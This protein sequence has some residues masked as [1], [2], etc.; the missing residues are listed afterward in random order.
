MTEIS[1]SQVSPTALDWALRHVR[2]HGDTDIFPVPFEYAVIEYYWDAVRDDLAKIPLGQAPLRA[3]VAMCI[4]KTHIGFR[5]AHQLDPFD[6][7]MYTAQVY[8]M[9]TYI[10]DSRLDCDVACSYRFKPTEDG[11]FYPSDNGWRSYVNRSRLLAGNY[12][13]VLYIDI[14]DFYNQIYHHRLCGSLEK[15]GIS[16]TRAKNVEKFLGRF[17]AR[18]SRGIPVGPS[19]SSLL[20]ECC[21]NDVDAY[22][23]DLSVPFVRYV[24]DFRI[25]SDRETLTRVL[26]ELTKLLYT[27]HRLT[28]QVGKTSVLAASEF[29]REHLEDPKHTFDDEV[30]CRIEQLAVSL[31]DLSREMGY[32]NVSLTDLPDEQKAEECNAVLKESFQEALQSNPTKLGTLRHL[33]RLARDLGTP[34]VYALVLDNLQALIPIIGDICRYLQRMAPHRQ[35]RSAAI[36]DVLTSAVVNSDYA[37]S[38]FVAMWILHLLSARPD[39][40]PYRRAMDFARRYKEGLGIRPQALLARAH[41]QEY[42]V[43]QHKESL[44]SLSPWDRRAVIW[45][46]SVLPNSERCAW[47][48]DERQL[49][50]PLEAAIAKYVKKAPLILE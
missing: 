22:L 21:L 4:P 34:E 42:W 36:G 6:T 29:V 43:R 20:A 37:S 46:A 23:R 17:T 50:D 3:H 5:V 47:L 38:E 9:G 49:S 18:Q 32:G 41:S 2:R 33:L 35:G 11:D 40:M 48:R 27:N 15:C 45:A 26:A 16:A 24:D 30:D 28:I 1:K 39:L 31:S 7:L 10:E 25:F 13:H 12:T 44:M 19:G 8:E 14:A